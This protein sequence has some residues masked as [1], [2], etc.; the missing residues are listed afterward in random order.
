[1]RGRSSQLVV[2][3]L[4]MTMAALLLL[5]L[6]GL[7]VS[8]GFV[9]FAAGWSNPAVLPALWLSLETTLLSLLI[10]LVLGTPLAW[11]VARAEGSRGAM[12][13]SLLKLP[14][15][16]P[17]AVAGVALLLTFGGSSW[18]GAHLAELGWS[19]VFTKTA[20]VLAQVFVAAPYYL[21]AAISAFR[22]VDSGLL[23]V[24]RSLGAGP[25][26]TFFR[27]A[28][29]L[30]APALFS[31]AAMSWARA[32]GEFG[33][34]LMFAGNLSGRTQTMPLAIFAAL[35]SDLKAAQAL[36]MVLVFA[37]LVVLLGTSFARRLGA[38][39]REVQG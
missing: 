8:T 21:S 27:I 32:L 22:A 39:V 31:G 11:K 6:L 2:W 38:P 7:A 24:A 4:S 36:S 19:V 23:W 37:A 17:P 28:L 15:V 26:R 33:A 30:A 20:V 25:A 9:E 1:M 18:L 34:T 12:F 16:I 3:L 35:E 13:E 29:P 14:M 5:P 10:T